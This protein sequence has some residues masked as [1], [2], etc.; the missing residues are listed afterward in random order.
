MAQ[1]NGSHLNLILVVP[2]DSGVV[3]EAALLAGVWGLAGLRGD[4]GFGNLPSRVAQTLPPA[5][6]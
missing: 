6:R 3:D 4:S 1:I 2:S 5:T